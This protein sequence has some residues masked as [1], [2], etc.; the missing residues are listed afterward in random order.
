MTAA[1]AR[2][3]Q[4]SQLGEHIMA[5]HCLVENQ[6]LFTPSE[7]A[8]AFAIVRRQGHL[9]PVTLSD[10][11]WRDWTGLDP[12]SKE[13]A[14]KGLQK[15]TFSMDGRGDRAKI[16]F[17]RL[18]L[19]AWA[20]TTRSASI[21]AKPRTEGR[22]VD[23]K[24]G[25]KVHQECRDQG[26]AMLRSDQISSCTATQNAK[27]V[28]QTGTVSGSDISLP[29][30]RTNSMQNKLS[31]VPA[32]SLAKR[33]SQTADEAWSQTL[34]AM[35][36]FLPAVGV[37][38]LLRLV[39]VIVG[40]FGGGV[41]DSELAAAVR[42]AGIR[43]NQNGA[44][45]WLHTVPDALAA[46]RRLDRPLKRPDEPGGVSATIQQV[47]EVLKARGAPFDALVAQLIE[48]QTDQESPR[49]RLGFD[50]FYDALTTIEAEIYTLAAGQL[51]PADRLAVEDHGRKI[52]LPF[53]TKLPADEVSR[54]S[55]DAQRRA[56]FD[57][58]K[59]PRLV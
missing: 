15:K 23:P 24:P 19:E 58:L 39:A 2:Q 14:I 52:S 29:G 40:I 59:I 5:Y 13:L 49:P 57:F 27:P 54:I 20:Q 1:P 12:R 53:F 17:N 46:L 31:L 56:T 36:A 21:S 7:R 35:Q 10:K 50:Q 43:P 32:S 44:G 22:R 4:Y 55:R 25:A 47:A 41:E 6:A 16:S 42:F 28:S 18:Q 34:A 30:S 48:L 45:L 3:P 9:M 38:F 26:C 8:L 33:V 51:T 37:A 11:N